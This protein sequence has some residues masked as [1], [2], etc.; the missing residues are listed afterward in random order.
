MSII[1]PFLRPFHRRDRTA[2]LGQLK[3]VDCWHF[4]LLRKEKMPLD[5][6]ADARVAFAQQMHQDLRILVVTIRAVDS[7]RDWIGPPVAQDNHM[8]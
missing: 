7:D 8:F 6:V 2:I 3:L 4:S 5:P 1:P